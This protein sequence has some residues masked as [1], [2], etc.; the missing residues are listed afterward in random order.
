MNKNLLRCYHRSMVAVGTWNET[1]NWLSP[2]RAGQTM[3]TIGGYVF[4][5]GGWTG[6]Y[7]Y[8]FADF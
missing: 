2:A 3:T 7:E 6:S 1:P 4:M 5:T 8:T